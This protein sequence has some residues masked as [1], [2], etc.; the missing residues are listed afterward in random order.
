MSTGNDPAGT[1]PRQFDGGIVVVII[2]VV[3]FG[4]MIAAKIST[5]RDRDF[6]RGQCVGWAEAQG[7]VAGWD[8]DGN[9]ILGTPAA[10]D[11]PAE[12]P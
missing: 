5:M 2:A 4:I 10:V 3:F 12:A 9:C 7:L 1:V 11:A 8:E 6:A